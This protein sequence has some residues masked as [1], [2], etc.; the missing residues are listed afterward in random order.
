MILFIRKLTFA[1]PYKDAADFN[2]KQPKSL[3]HIVAIINTPESVFFSSLC[4]KINYDTG[5]GLLGI[6]S[7][8]LSA[9]VA[10]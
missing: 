6:V 9:K 1:A 10:I 4:S 2:G 5:K 7:I 8:F 3:S